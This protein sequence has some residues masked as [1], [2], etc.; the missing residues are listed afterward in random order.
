MALPSSIFGQRIPGLS[1]RSMPLSRVTICVPLVTAGSSPTLATL[2]LRER[3]DEGRLADV[4]DADDHR[5]R[6]LVRPRVELREACCTASAMRARVSPPR[7]S[8]D[9]DGPDRGVVRGR[10][11]RAARVPSQRRVT[12]GSA[13]SALAENLQAGLVPRSSV[14]TGFALARG[15]RASSTSM[16]TSCPGIASAIALPGLGH[17]T[18]VPLDGPATLVPPAGPACRGRRGTS[19]PT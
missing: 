2:A 5:A 17:V 11:E 19:P 8:A 16:T 12:S 3:V 13:R 9:G 14:T 4:G 15:M 10:S 6:R 7:P 1:D 18:R